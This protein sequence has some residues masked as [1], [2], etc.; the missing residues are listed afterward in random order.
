M[1]YTTAHDNTVIR[2]SWPRHGPVVDW[3]KLEMIPVKESP[4]IANA[5]MKI[6]NII[7]TIAALGLAAGFLAA[8]ATER[9][10][11]EKEKGAKEK[12]AQLEAQAKITKAEAEKLALAKVPGGTIKEGGIEKEKGKLIWSFDIATPGSR[13]ITEVQVDA[14]SGEIVDIAKETVAEQEKEKKE[15]AKK[16]KKEKEEENEKEEK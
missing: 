10:G 11:E 12:T 16:G 14:I 13:D 9:E 4:K 8:C 15:D 1:T 2:S 6:T 7:C 5:N 3:V